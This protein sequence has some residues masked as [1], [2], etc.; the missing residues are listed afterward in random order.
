MQ[1]TMLNKNLYSFSIK[2][3]VAFIFT[4]ESINLRGLIQ[5]AIAYEELRQI[6]KSSEIPCPVRVILERHKKGLI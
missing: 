2:Y 3:G 6:T 1:L 5:I 4:D